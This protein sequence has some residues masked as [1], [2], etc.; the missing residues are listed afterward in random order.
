[1][2]VFRLNAVPFG[3]ILRSAQDDG[4]RDVSLLKPAL[5]TTDE[6]KYFRPQT[7]ISSL[8]CPSGASSFVVGLET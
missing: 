6:C 2:Y 5:R 4:I 3:W 7:E 8:F 1:V